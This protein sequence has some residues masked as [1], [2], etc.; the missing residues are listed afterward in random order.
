M[1][2]GRVTF[3]KDDVILTDNTPFIGLQWAISKLLF[4][5][6]SKRV[7]VLNYCKGN[8]FDSHKNTQ[9]ISI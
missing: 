3:S 8:E 2:Y 5:S 7:L 9:L 4:V 1:R 6:V